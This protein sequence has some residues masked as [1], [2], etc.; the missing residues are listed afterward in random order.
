MPWLWAH[1][2]L[3]K[4]VA[5]KTKILKIIRM[6]FWRNHTYVPTFFGLPFSQ[7]TWKY[8]L[9]FSLNIV[10]SNTLCTKVQGISLRWNNLIRSGVVFGQQFNCKTQVCEWHCYMV[11]YFGVA[12]DFCFWPFWTEVRPVAAKVDFQVPRNLIHIR[13]QNFGMMMSKDINQQG[14]YWHLPARKGHPWLCRV[15]C[16]S[17]GLLEY[18]H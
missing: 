1:E 4:N 17:W 10:K 11:G 13:S 9:L 2:F 15:T 16:G 3:S 14:D 18:I 6:C 8:G 12:L 5:A 7:I